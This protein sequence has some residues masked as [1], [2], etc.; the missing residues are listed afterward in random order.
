[1]INKKLVP[2]M[3]IL[4]EHKYISCKFNIFFFTFI[5]L[6]CVRFSTPAGIWASDIDGDGMPDWWEQGILDVSR[7]DA[8]EDPDH[9]GLLN[10]EEFNY[11][12]HPLERDTDADGIDDYSEIKIYN[13]DPLISDTDG[14]GRSDGYELDLG[15]NPKNPHDDAYNIPV[16]TINLRKEWNLISIPL[17]QENSSIE[18]IL[19]S[20]SGLYSVVWAYIDGK[21][22]AYDPE[23]PIFSDLKHMEPG[24]GY[25]IR[26][27]EAGNLKLTGN[28]SKSNIRLE[29]GWNLVGYNILASQ[30]IQDALFSI[31]GCLISVWAYI[32]GKWRLYDPASPLFSDLEA[33]EYGKGYWINVR[34]ACTWTLP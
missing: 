27:K 24:V 6:I 23:F 34:K 31:K 32:D 17:I 10:I 14:G 13:T 29:E 12:T 28:I 26:M 8:R 19:S 1:M 30:N 9:D 7:N 20:I 25:W 21:W 15:K 3:T 16:I 11:G 5:L 33:M 2:V 4:T 18:S 22:K